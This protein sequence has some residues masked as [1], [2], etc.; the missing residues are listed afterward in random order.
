MACKI[1]FL[2]LQLTPIDLMK[3][4]LAIL[5]LLL[6][7]LAFLAH[8]V[9]PHHHH[10]N[11]TCFVVSHC[12]DGDSHSHDEPA[13]NHDHSEGSLCKIFQDIV[14]S[15]SNDQKFKAEVNDFQQLTLIVIPEFVYLTDLKGENVFFLQT[16]SYISLYESIIVSSQG[17]R[18]PPIC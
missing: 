5:F 16:D 12:D 4:T 15:G 7:N 11:A 2:P 1:I 14:P 17:L 13:H 3:K 10:G 18:A 6:A 9:V 8:V